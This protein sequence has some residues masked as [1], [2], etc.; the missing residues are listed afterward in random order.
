M[1]LSEIA[2]RIGLSA[3]L[4]APVSTACLH[5]T[6]SASSKMWV[7]VDLSLTD[8]GEAMCNGGGGSTGNLQCKPGYSAH[9]HWG[10]ILNPIH[11][12]YN[13]PH[14]S[15]AL[16]LPNW[17]CDHDNCCPRA[18]E[19]DGGTGDHAPC[20]CW[21]CQYDQWYFCV[22]VD[23]EEEREGN[24]TLSIG[25]GGVPSVTTMLPVKS[26]GLTGAA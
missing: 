10:V 1:R 13:T 24:G 8:N 11:I 23:G 5:V 19:A 16:E 26:T 21:E 2:G 4:L 25:E 22:K 7:S 9:Y 12:D 20:Q 15:F 18:R 6:G 14:G 3:L 17:K